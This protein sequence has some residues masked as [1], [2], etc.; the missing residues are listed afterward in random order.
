MSLFEKIKKLVNEVRRK[1]ELELIKL[2]PPPHVEFT[3]PGSCIIT[4]FGLGAPC[5]VSITTTT[6]ISVSLDIDRLICSESMCL[7]PGNWMIVFQE[8]KV[9]G[10]SEVQCR[11]VRIN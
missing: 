4:I 10:K 5:Q 11:A 6:L 1:N 3:S 9:D 8:A 7:S 2:T